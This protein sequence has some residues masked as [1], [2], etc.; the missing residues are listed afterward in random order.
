MV[1][2]RPDTVIVSVQDQV[3]TSLGDEAVI[4]HLKDGIYYGLNP[5]GAHI[6]RLLEEPRTFGEIRDIIL[7]EYEVE[8]QRCEQDLIKL[9]QELADRKLIEVRGETAP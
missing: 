8:P 6:W 9:L 5:L 7:E 4:L 3:S 1:N 2:F